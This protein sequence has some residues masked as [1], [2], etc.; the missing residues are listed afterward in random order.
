MLLWVAHGGITQWCSMCSSWGSHPMAIPWSGFGT[1]HWGCHGMLLG[2]AH[3][4]P[5]MAIPWNGL[6]TSHGGI[7]WHA[8]MGSSWGSHPMAIP[9]N[10]IGTSHGGIPWHASMDSSWGSHPNGH[11]MEWHW[12]FSWVDSMECFYGALCAA[13]GDHTQWPFNGMALAP[14]IGDAMECF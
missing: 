13:H 14:L 10:G 3:V 6:G 1:S 4:V 2:L 8:S 5:P 11:S 7:H 12:G 9:W